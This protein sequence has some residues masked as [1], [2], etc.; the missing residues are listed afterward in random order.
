MTVNAIKKGYKVVEI[1]IN[2][3]S[4]IGKSKLHPIRDGFRMIKSIISITYRQTS[5]ISKTIIFSSLMFS[6]LGLV[7][8]LISIYEK[9]VYIKLVH[10]Y[11]PL[12]SVFLIIVAIQLFS[13]AL[14]FDHLSHKMDRILEFVKNK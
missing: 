5:L 13:I 10:E 3:R 6:F 14:L 2:Y 9:M 1:P 11:Y 8:G 7:F 12:V 4:R